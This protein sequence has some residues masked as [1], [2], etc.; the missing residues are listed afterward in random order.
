MPQLDVSTYASQLLW[1]VL[2]FVPLYLIVY[3]VVLPRISDVL[4]ARQDKIDD[5]LKKAAARRD[6]AETVLA[7]YERF[8]A[9]AHAKGQESIRAVQEE[10]KADAVRRN[11]ELSDKLAEQTAAAEQRIHA[12]KAEALAN[13]NATVAEV[14]TSAATKL[15]GET[16]SPDLVA[17]A[18]GKATGEQG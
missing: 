1:L 8:Q 17:Q 6:E 10:I 9:D 5:D 14:V 12:A 18:I 15:V 13:L 4:E 11:Q 3:K 2:T 7:E 16:P